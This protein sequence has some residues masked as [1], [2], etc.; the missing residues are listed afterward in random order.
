[1]NSLVR[2]HLP[3][4]YFEEYESLRTILTEILTDDDLRAQLGG[5]TPTL[6]ALCREIGETQHSYIES[7]RTFRQDFSYRHRDARVEMSVAALSA[8]YFTLDEDLAAAIAAL[9]DDDIA[10]RRIVRDDFEIDAFSPLPAVQVD[11]YREALLIFYGKVSV[12]LRS[13][14]KPLPP[15]WREWIG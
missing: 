12:Y 1:V 8:W 2:D 4:T 11:I 15:R 13:L 3:A 7:F 14:D 5:T 10:N 9:S 6:G